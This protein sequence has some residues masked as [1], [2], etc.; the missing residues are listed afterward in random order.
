MS[1]FT[2][3][4][5]LLLKHMDPSD[6]PPLFLLWDI[7][8]VLRLTITLKKA[9]AIYVVTA[10]WFQHMTR[11][12]HTTHSYILRDIFLSCRETF[13]IIFEK[14]HIMN[15]KTCTIS[16][17]N[18][19]KNNQIS[20]NFFSTFHSTWHTVTFNEV[21]TDLCVEGWTLHKNGNK[22]VKNITPSILCP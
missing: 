22:T 3:P 1:G 4:P 10:E 14:S 18:I 9:T 17:S 15:P 2:F 20:F 19:Q 11:P 6:P 16:I 7:Y 21:H 8:S 12:N 13:P 5:F